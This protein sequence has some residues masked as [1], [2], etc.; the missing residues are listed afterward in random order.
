[1]SREQKTAEFRARMDVDNAALHRLWHR[2]VSATHSFL[3]P[4]DF[5]SISDIVRDQY[6]PNAPLS[7]ALIDGEIVGFM[8]MSGG[9]IDSLFIDPDYIGCGLGRQFLSVA[10]QSGTP[11]TVDVN[12]QNEAAL[13][14]YLSQGFVETRRTETDSDGRPYPLIFMEKAMS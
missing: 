8:G 1:M 10:E 14:F 3:T 7:V 6:V 5:Q 13:A 11:L 12:A 2:S 4:D 9:H